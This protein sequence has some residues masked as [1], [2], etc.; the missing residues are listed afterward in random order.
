[1]RYVTEPLAY[2]SEIKVEDI[3]YIEKFDFEGEY[4]KMMARMRKRLENEQQQQHATN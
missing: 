1:L 2:K 4:E 3:K